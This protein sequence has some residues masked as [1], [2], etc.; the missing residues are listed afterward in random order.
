MAEESD[1][2]KPSTEG[3]LMGKGSR[4]KRVACSLNLAETSPGATIAIIEDPGAWGD[5]QELV[6]YLV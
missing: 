2:K 4:A 3:L 5:C 6:R 1:W